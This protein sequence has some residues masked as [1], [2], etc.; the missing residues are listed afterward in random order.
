MFKKPPQVKS[1]A[2]IKSSERRHLLAE[3][4]K[5]CNIDKSNLSKDQELHLLPATTKKATYHSVQEHKGTIYFDADETPLWFQIRD[6]RLYPTVYTLWK[7]AYLLP[8]ILTNEYVVERIVG[9]A[10]LMLP[11]CIPPIDK[12]AIRGAL[13]AVADYK[14]PSVIMAVGTCSLNIAQFDSVLGRLGTAVTILHHYDDELYRLFDGEVAIPEEV[15]TAPPQAPVEDAAAENAPGE[16]APAELPEDT[17]GSGEEAAT[18]EPDSLAEAVDELAVEDLDNFFIRAFIQAV[19]VSK[20]NLPMSS[21]TFMS[22]Y[23]LK[24]LPRMDTKY[25]NVKRT[26]WKKFAKFLKALEKLN[27]ITLKGKGDDFTI[28]A[29]SVPPETLQNF[30]TH[31]TIETGAKSGGAYTEPK[32]ASKMSVVSLYK[33]TN[34]TRMVITKLNMDYNVFYSALE[35]KDMMNKYIKE[36]DLADKK[37]PQQ[38]VLDEYLSSAISSKNTTMKRGEIFAPFLAAF[39]PHYSILLPG[40]SIDRGSIKKGQPKK[41]KILT[42]TVLGRKKTTTVSEFEQFHIKPQTLADEL[43]NKCSG[44]TAIGPSKHN[45]AVTEVMVQGPHGPT[46]IEFLKSKGVPVSYIEF[47]DKSKGKKKR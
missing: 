3:I 12:R 17:P 38:V 24:N 47:E 44:S 6:S 19:K 7:A 9:N 11:G 4:C 32:D 45:P 21:S 25:A 8:I 31:K 28:T 22:D 43:K 42:Q 40:S 13:V 20:V 10:N 34:K 5:Q 15:D 1:A 14:R 41:I 29:I 37:N 39:S 33:P 36:A 27:Y 16:N 35:A 23:I 30:V 26:S 46:I 18:E 2:N